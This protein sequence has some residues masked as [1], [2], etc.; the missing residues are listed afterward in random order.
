MIL[1]N[2]SRDISDSCDSSNSSDSSDSSDS[3]NSSDS[4]DNSDSSAICDEKN[5]IFN[6]LS[7]VMRGKKN[8]NEKD[9]YDEKEFGTTNY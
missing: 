6:F 7:I 9:L 2:N 4:S 8:C 1:Y 5:I 3:S